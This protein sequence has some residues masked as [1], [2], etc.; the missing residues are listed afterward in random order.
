MCSPCFVVRLEVNLKD[1]ETFFH[2]RVVTSTIVACCFD[3]SYNGG[4]IVL[5]FSL[6]SRDV[7]FLSS[8][9]RNNILLSIFV[10]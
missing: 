7:E 1:L 6:L 10:S 4:N 2:T 3:I 8:L 5:E 9:F